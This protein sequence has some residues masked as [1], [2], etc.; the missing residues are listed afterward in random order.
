VHVPLAG[1][2]LGEGQHRLDLAEVDEHR[3]RV[4]ALLDDARDDVALVPGVL[5]ER[6]LVFHVAQPLQDHLPGGGRGDAA[7][8]RRGVV[9]L[10]ARRAVRARLLGP[11]RDV[12]GLP[13][14]IDPRRHV[15][16]VRLV[17]GHQQRV[18]DRL[19]RRF[20][21]DVLLALETAQH[22]QVNVHRRQ[23]Q[24]RCRRT[25]RRQAPDH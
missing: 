8:A 21:R 22:A 3:A 19:D 20:G 25:P 9:V 5:A 12:S 18:L 15:G 24:G 1:H 13:V 16:A 11:D 23:L 10:P 4:L 6:H 14:H 17:V 2:L 7:E